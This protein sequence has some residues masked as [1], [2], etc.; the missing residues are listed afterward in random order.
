M[1]KS[2]VT[3][4]LFVALGA[5]LTSGLARTGAAA[6]TENAAPGVVFELGGTFTQVMTHPYFFNVSSIR[7]PD[8]RVWMDTRPIRTELSFKNS[9]GILNQL[10]EGT[11]AVLRVDCDNLRERAETQIEARVGEERRWHEGAAVFASVES[12]RE[13]CR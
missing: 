9:D 1:Q 12:F 5:L 8:N 6:P 13:I 7:A 4:V 2:K 11:S 3:A 10:R